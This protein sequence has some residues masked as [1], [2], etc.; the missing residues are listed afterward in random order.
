MLTQPT[1]DK[2][3]ILRLAGMYQQLPGNL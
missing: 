2:L 3:Q 1:L